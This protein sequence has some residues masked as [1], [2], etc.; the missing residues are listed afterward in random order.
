[1]IVANVQIVKYINRILTPENVDKYISIEK[2]CVDLIE[3]H[4]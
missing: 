4:Y 3:P 1:M 2:L